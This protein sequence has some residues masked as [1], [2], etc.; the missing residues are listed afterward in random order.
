[1][2]Q[3]FSADTRVCSFFPFPQSLYC[4]CPL[5]ALS[6]V[7]V[8]PPSVISL[9]LNNPKN[10]RMIITMVPACSQNAQYFLL[11]RSCNPEYFVLWS[12]LKYLYS[13]STPEY[14]VL[15][16]L[17]FALCTQEYFVLQSTVQVLCTLYS[18]VLVL[19]S[20]FVVQ[21]T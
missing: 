9:M 1:M 14:F 10:S 16:T 11:R 15:C 5:K 19:Q 6:K 7:Q 8:L 18:R 2:M 3:P 4:K 21:T 20:T 13:W 17:Y 12:T